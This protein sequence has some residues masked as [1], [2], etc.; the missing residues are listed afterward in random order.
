MGD[1]TA[2]RTATPAGEASLAR[3][4]E[5][6]EVLGV[7]GE[8]PGVGGGTVRTPGSCLWPP[9]RLHARLP[10]VAARWPA[11]VHG[12]FAGSLSALTASP[13]FLLLSLW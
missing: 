12:F 7:S 1:G 2:S 10:S 3:G 4:Q 6:Q 13:G 11:F 5:R 8:Q 9:W